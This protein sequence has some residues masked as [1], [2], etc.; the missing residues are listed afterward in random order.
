ML[1]DAATRA[2]YDNLYVQDG[3]LR[4]AALNYLLRATESR[5]DWAYEVWDDLLAHLPHKNNHVRTIA[6]H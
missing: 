1:M 6:V 3:D 2:Q 4:Y 5:V